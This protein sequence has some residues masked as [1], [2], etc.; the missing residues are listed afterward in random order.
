MYYYLLVTGT[1]L[2]SLAVYKTVNLAR[3]VAQARAVGL[4]Y[5]ITPIL[6]TEFFGLLITPLLRYL[7]HGYLD[8]GKGWPR[9]CRFIIKDWQW[10][11][12]RRAHDEYGDVFLCVSP[13]GIICYSADAEMAWDVMNRRNDFIKP[14]DKYKLLEIYGPNVVTAEGATYRFHV[15]MT[16]PPFRDLSGVNDLVWDETVHQTRRLSED[17]SKESRRE[18]HMDVSS[19]TLAVIS[20]A[21]FGKRV[22]RVNSTEDEDIPQGYRISFLKAIDTTA[23]HMVPILLFPGWLMNLIPHLRPVRLAHTQL[24]DYIRELIR[25]ERA[26][27]ERDANYQNQKARSN[28]LT[29]VVRVSRTEA[30][31]DEKAAGP[32]QKGIFTERETIGNLFIYLLAGEYLSALL[33]T[34]G[35]RTDSR[36]RNNSQRDR[37][38]SCASCLAS[39]YTVQSHSGDRCCGC[40]S[41]ISRTERALIQRRLREA[42]L[43][44][45]V[46]GKL[47]RHAMRHFSLI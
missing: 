26:N 36:L 44:L 33:W 1:L 30:Q 29:S 16:A 12:K 39:R 10:E 43:H 21:G 32:A 27:L 45:C 25:S 23:T 47:S 19:L 34:H 8:Q 13:E 3:Y 14:A 22:E 46:H 31:N 18:L 17:W 5:V 38:C 35:L 7:Y 9:W 41:K 6:E 11:D 4:P 2:V 40:R 42:R 37:L 15:R 28:L 20:L 24:E